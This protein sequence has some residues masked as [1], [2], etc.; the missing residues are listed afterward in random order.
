[1]LNAIVGVLVL[2]HTIQVGVSQARTESS[3]EATIS[4]SLQLLDALAD[5]NVELLKVSGDFK[6]ERQ[7]WPHDDDGAHHL[8]LRRNVTMIGDPKLERQAKIDMGF[9]GTRVVVEEGYTLKVRD[10]HFVCGADH[11]D[12]D[13]ALFQI[14]S[15]VPFFASSGSG[16]LVYDDIIAEVSKHPKDTLESH[17]NALRDYGLNASIADEAT[18]LAKE[19]PCQ[20]GAFFIDGLLPNPSGLDTFSDLTASNTLQLIT[21]HTKRHILE[22]ALVDGV[23]SFRRALEDP[24]VG[25]IFFV[26]DIVFDIG[27]WPDGKG[28][29]DETLVINRRVSVLTHPWVK[30]R[31][32]DPAVWDMNL[33]E[34]ML[35]I[36]KGGVV[37]IKGMVLRRAVP[38]KAGIGSLGFFD[39]ERG[40]FVRLDHSVVCSPICKSILKSIGGAGFG[41][42]GAVRESNCSSLQPKKADVDC[43][44]SLLLDGK[45]EVVLNKLQSVTNA[46]SS[47]L[48]NFNFDRTVVALGN[49]NTV[50][51]AAEE[52]AAQ[53]LRVVVSE[54]DLQ[55][56]L[57]N[58]KITTVHVA[59]N[60]ELTREVW[61]NSTIS[62]ISLDRGV[63]I[64]S[65]PALK[66]VRLDMG[67]L[68]D[69]VQLMEDVVLRLTML[70]LGELEVDVMNPRISIP[71][72]NLEKGGVLKVKDSVAHI[73]L[74]KGARLE[75]GIPIKLPT[76]S[77]EVSV[78]STEKCQEVADIDCPQ[79]AFH[80]VEWSSRESQNNPTAAGNQKGHIAVTNMLVVGQF[81][82][83]S[84]ASHHHTENS[85][86]GKSLTKGW[87]LAVIALAILT[88]VVLIGL[89][90]GTVVM[91]RRQKRKEAAKRQKK[92]Q[93]AKAR[94]IST[95]ELVASVSIH[96]NSSDRETSPP[97]RDQPSIEMYQD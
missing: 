29:L 33:A 92:R 88:A 79:N 7:H 54:V 57:L 40:A 24:H 74:E 71:F 86:G 42:K 83:D 5:E 11:R 73:V 82:V 44:E 91:T 85:G 78:V 66:L 84:T 50:K 41:A 51:S 56:A 60:L 61:G 16:R 46:G 52:A 43:V 25:W 36:E 68:V 4:S 39:A 17:V 8:A 87:M 2:L 15:L 20:L 69:K 75:I 48:T 18:C 31:K 62:A 10:L 34:N 35:T 12:G 6:L 67:T 63:T 14:Q 27:Q 23:A 93:E 37:S 95:E 13:H 90:Y 58:K 49:E 1:M 38:G 59:R 77:N 47:A 53:G 64:T 65:H 22:D 81:E 80:L 94:K 97:F 76:I 32:T 55:S 30:P 26:K 72:V 28:N 9:M 89:I 3:K 70:D 45:G 19:V 21:E 96:V